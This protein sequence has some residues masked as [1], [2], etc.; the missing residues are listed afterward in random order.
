[1]Q[2]KYSDISQRKDAFE[3]ANTSIISNEKKGRVKE[4]YSVMYIQYETQT[5]NYCGKQLVRLEFYFFQ[6]QNT[7]NFPILPFEEPIDRSIN[8]NCLI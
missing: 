6:A 4:L 3:Y 1:M 2:K 8:E 5:M 7:I